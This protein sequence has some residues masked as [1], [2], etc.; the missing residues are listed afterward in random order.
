MKFDMLNTK[1]SIPFCVSLTV[2]MKTNICIYVDNLQANLLLLMHK[3]LHGTCIILSN[4][5]FN[6]QLS[7]VKAFPHW[8]RYEK[9]RRIARECCFHTERETNVRFLLIHTC[10]LGGAD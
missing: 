1:N 3:N 2:F 8:T 7:R 10:T 6:Q 5:Q 4:Q 9:A